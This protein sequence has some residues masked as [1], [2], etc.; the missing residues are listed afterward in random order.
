[1]DR[2]ACDLLTSAKRALD[3]L[4]SSLADT[5]G[6]VDSHVSTG[7]PHLSSL[8]HP[9]PGIRESL[10]RFS[11][12]RLRTNPAPRNTAVDSQAKPAPARRLP[13]LSARAFTPEITSCQASLPV[14]VI[15]CSSQAGWPKVQ[16]TMHRLLQTGTVTQT[17]ESPSVFSRSPDL[18]LA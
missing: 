7:G 12:W 17:R 11:S 10:L 8:C 14:H 6:H 2:P 16:W 13:C 1:M 3:A 4:I 15:K 5:T 18:S 9:L